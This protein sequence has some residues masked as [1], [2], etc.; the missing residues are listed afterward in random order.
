MAFDQEKQR[1]EAIVEKHADVTVRPEFS[2]PAAS[3]L[4][5]RCRT[6]NVAVP[7]VIRRFMDRAHG[8]RPASN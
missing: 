5:H 6:M 7:L 8:P 1:I 2:A 4:E 3:L